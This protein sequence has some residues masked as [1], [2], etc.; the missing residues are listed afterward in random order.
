[1]AITIDDIMR[2]SAPKKLGILAGLIVLITALFVF[3]SIPMMQKRKRERRPT[4]EDQ[5]RGI[6]VLIPLPRKR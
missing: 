5:V 2:L 3:A 6:S 4:Y 1:M